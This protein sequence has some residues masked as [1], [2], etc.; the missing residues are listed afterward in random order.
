VTQA[1]GLSEFQGSFYQSLYGANVVWLKS[2]NG[3]NAA[4]MNWYNLQ[5]DGTLRPWNGSTS[6]ASIHSETPVLA[7]FSPA[8]FNNPN[9]VLNPP[10]A[11]GITA[12]VSGNQVTFS[13]FSAAAIGKTYYVAALVGDG[14]S[15]ATAWT[16]F[17]I[18][19]Q[20]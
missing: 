8:Y 3:N 13:G 17:A 6:A 1:L 5:T 10:Q 15:S 11:T 19:V 2:S 9:M 20:A 18:T 7:T 4:N 14:V 16:V 12:S